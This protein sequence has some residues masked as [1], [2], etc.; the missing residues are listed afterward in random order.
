MK[1]IDFKK[2]TNYFSKLLYK[3]KTLSF[4]KYILL[5]YLFITIIGSLL[6]YMPASFKGNKQI[7][8]I[9]ALF[10]SASS[11]SDTGLTTLAT[12]STWTYFGQGII[13]ML[14]LIGGI[15]WFSLKVYLFN[16][17]LG[18]PITFKT[19]EI[20]AAERGGIQVGETRKIIKIS[21]TVLFIILFI[22]SF[23]LTLYFYFSKP[24]EQPFINVQSKNMYFENP[25]HNIGIS[26]RWGIFHAISALNNAGFDI[27]GSN[28]LQPFY[29]DYGLQI[30]FMILFIIGGIG[31]PVIYD[32]YQWGKSKI[33]KEHFKWS[34]FTKISMIT[35]VFV[36]LIGLALVFT[37]ELTRLTTKDKIPF[38]QDDS[39]GSKGNKV[40][41]LIFNT[42]S[43]RNAGFATIKMKSLSSATLI[44]YSMMM[45]IGSAPSSTA[46]GIRTITFALVI[47]SLW[48][49]LR[50]RNNVRV[51]N[52]RL[53]KK[54]VNNSFVATLVSLFLVLTTSFVLFTSFKEY[55]G[56]LNQEFIKNSNNEISYSF[57]D[58][59]FEVASAFGT[60]GLSTGITSQISLISKLLLIVLMFIGQL[61]VSS[62]LL[63]WDSK[64][65]NQRKFEFIKEDLTTG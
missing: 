41:A 45:F 4:V 58:L 64:D 43:T 12:S 28:S 9:D 53:P 22:S 3:L 30:I 50:G 10:T 54:T 35:Y 56:N 25:R 60:T 49:R 8:Y 18:R 13:A 17:I 48:S 16:I 15:G 7:D 52:K 20:V 26:L 46:G 6:L 44:I 21:I 19:N 38:W 61:G 59:L 40:M 33:T 1:N 27:I 11:F 2:I 51:F 47:L 65:N 34:L 32:I 29:N 55:G 23:T 42:F 57:V 36:S 14:I 31:Y 62:S 37:F 24:L 63:F 39:Y 5:F